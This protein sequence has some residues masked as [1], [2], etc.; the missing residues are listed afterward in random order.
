MF[1]T[2]DDD[3][4]RDKKVQLESE[5]ADR[6]VTSHSAAGVSESSTRHTNLMTEL[7]ALLDVM[8]ERKLIEAKPTPRRAYGII[9]IGASER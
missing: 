3:R 1:R 6:N 9:S 2:W 4:L 7:R 5:L 8:R